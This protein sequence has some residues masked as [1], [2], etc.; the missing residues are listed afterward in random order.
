MKPLPT[1]LVSFDWSNN[2]GAIDVEVDRFA[3]EEDSEV[4]FMKF[5]PT[6]T[7]KL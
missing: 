2:C 1:Y 3:L 4:S 7:F 5:L 6:S